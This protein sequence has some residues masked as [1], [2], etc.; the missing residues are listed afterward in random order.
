MV[1]CVFAMSINA[2]GIHLSS[3]EEIYSNIMEHVLL[4]ISACASH[5]YRSNNLILLQLPFYVETVN[6]YSKR[7]EKIFVQLPFRCEKC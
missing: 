2:I 7:I 1:V 6:R 4:H 3:N 5:S